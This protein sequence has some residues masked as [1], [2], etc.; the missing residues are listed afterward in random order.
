MPSSRLILLLTLIV[1]SWATAAISCPFCSA[2]PHTISDD[3]EEATAAIVARFEAMTSETNGI[4]AYQMRIVGVLKGDPRLQGSV[5]E[6]ASTH[7]L[8]NSA[9]F[10]LTGFGD[11]PIQWSSPSSISSESIT[12]LQG[13]GDL[14]EVG[15]DRLKYFLRHLQHQDNFVADDAYNEFAEASLE[16]IACLSGSLDRE[17]VIRQIQDP[18]VPTHRRRLCWTFLSQC[19]TT[20]DAVLFDKTLQRRKVDPDFDPGM[21]AAIACYIA[22]G[23][24]PALA[25]IEREYMSN[26][27]SE[28]SDSFAAI[29]AIRVHGTDWDIIPRARL[30]SALRLVLDRPDL[31]DL[32]IP[33]LARWEDWSAID[34]IVKLFQDSTEETSLIKPAAV[35]YL[36]SCPLPAGAEALERLRMMD[37]QAVELAESS[38]MFYSGLPSLPVPP[39]D[40]QAPTVAEKPDESRTIR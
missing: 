1:A 11:E 25:R 30:A 16:D 13:L 18:S 21:D 32:V 26:A 9:S 17:W 37:S 22:L 27:A 6:V 3:L 5:V 38:M 40:H 8:S 29:S 39:P 7:Q 2:L 34:R 36:K 14:P 24:E 15:P 10:W 12:Y 31:A 4:R 33:D 23:G 28:Y 20:D 19:G 35:R